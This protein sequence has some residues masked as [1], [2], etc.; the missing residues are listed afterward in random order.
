MR[1]LL[2]IVVGLGVTGAIYY[3]SL[4]QGIETKEHVDDSVQ[5]AQEATDAYKKQQSEMMKQL[6]Q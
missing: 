2:F 3:M 1:L 4:S 6:G 5:K